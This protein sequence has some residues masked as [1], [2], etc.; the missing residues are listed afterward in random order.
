MKAIEGNV[1]FIAPPQ[2]AVLERSLIDLMDRSVEPLLNRYVR[3]DGS[4]MWPTT[5]DFS[6]IDGLDDAYESFHNWP[7]VYAMG[8]G[9]HLGSQSLRLYDAITRQFARYDCGHGH[10][11]VVKEYEQGYDWMH[12]G[13]GYELYYMLGFVDPTH[14]VNAERARRYAGFYMN[15][16]P[17]APNYDAERRMLRSP[18]VGSMG[19]AFRNFEKGYRQYRYEQ[20]KPWPLPFHDLPG[21]T[22][23]EDLKGSPDNEKRMGEAMVERMA[24]G[25]VVANLASTS[26]V[27]NAYLYTGEEKYR[28]WVADYLEAWMERAEKNGGLVPD[29]IGPSGEIGECMGGKWYGGYYGWTWPH[30]WHHIGDAVL[31]AAQN[32]TMMFQDR[33]YMDFARRQIQALVDQGREEEGTVKVPYFHHDGGWDGYTP[34]HARFLSHLWCCTMD[35][36]DRQLI[37]DLRDHGSRDYERIVSHFSKHGG[38]H[39][40]GWLAFLFGEYPDFPVD[41]LRHNCAQVYQR[42]AFMQDDRQDPAESGDWYL[43]VRNPIFAEGL[44]QLTSGGPLFNYN[45]GLQISRL[46]YFDAQRRRAGLPEDVAALVT[47]L[48][49]DDTPECGTTVELVNLHPT[50]GR[51]LV[52]QGGMFAEHTFTDVTHTMRRTDAEPAMHS[53]EAAYRAWVGEQTEERTEHVGD[54]HFAVRLAP[55]AGIRLKLGMRLFSAK[56]TYSWPL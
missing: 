50:E 46:R 55:C 26:L 6:S 2:W 51:E 44:V 4:V 11:M 18:H 23:V 53:S 42:L 38:N 56:P 34:M 41:I 3:D 32:A 9:D 5:D 39:E 40:A 12:Q 27:T 28:R 13:E 45:G 33:S 14:A 20:W 37:V 8:G 21:I 15:E 17:E 48:G 49:E 36:K 54:T 1:Q 16:D 25:D 22:C 43:Q 30:G 35:E 31:A 19:P 10:P 52:V 7:L 24:R 47:S 29:N